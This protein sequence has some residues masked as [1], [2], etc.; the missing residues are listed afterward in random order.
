MTKK[1]GRSWLTA[2]LTGLAL[3]AAGGGAARADIAITL[4][5][6]TPITSGPMA[7]DVLYTY[8]VFSNGTDQIKTGD[9]FTVNNFGNYVLGTA[10]GLFTTPG[11]FPMTTPGNVPGGTNLTLGYSGPTLNSPYNLGSFTA[12]STNGVTTT[13]MTLAQTTDYVTG[14]KQNTTGTTLAPLA[15]PEP[16]TLVPLASAVLLSWLYL[17][18]RRG[19][20]K[21]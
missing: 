21:P 6:A 8:S 1:L 11:F 9:F 14:V 12:V 7:G 18:R 5:S 4:D 19:A 17:R 2:A 16:G 13:V 3:A 15:T 10:T 20:A